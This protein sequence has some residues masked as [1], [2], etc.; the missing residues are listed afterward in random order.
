MRTQINSV[1]GFFASS[2]S[3]PTKSVPRTT[4]S[5]LVEAVFT[6]DRDGRNLAVNLCVKQAE[7]ILLKVV[8]QR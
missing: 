7:S 1:F 6:F 5:L 3:R 4:E 8:Y 2:S